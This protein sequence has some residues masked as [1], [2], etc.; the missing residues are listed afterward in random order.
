MHREPTATDR[1]MIAPFQQR[2][3]ARSAFFS[4]E[5]AWFCVDAATLHSVA[6]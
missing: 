3:S 2:Y 5:R 6:R 1:P 4:A